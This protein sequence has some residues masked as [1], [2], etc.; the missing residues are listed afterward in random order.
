MLPHNGWSMANLRG[1][2]LR[3]QQLKN[4]HKNIHTSINNIV[5]SCAG[6][7][8]LG[9]HYG[10]HC[11]FFSSRLK[12]SLAAII[13]GFKSIT[14]RKKT[15]WNF[16]IIYATFFYC[17]GKNLESRIP[18]LRPLSCIKF[19]ASVEHCEVYRFEFFL[20]RCKFFIKVVCNLSCERGAT[21]WNLF[22][23][24]LYRFDAL[25]NIFCFKNKCSCSFW[26]PSYIVVCW[27]QPCIQFCNS[28]VSLKCEILQLELVEV[29]FENINLDYIKFVVYNMDWCFKYILSLHKSS[30]KNGCDL[31]VHRKDID[32]A[33]KWIIWGIE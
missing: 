6:T 22:N 3:G 16:K 30:D 11:I 18:P 13:F 24:C 8:S 7:A 33:V 28:Y 25:V 4:T 21:I 26:V 31:T 19:I 9:L 23:A 2:H 15:F 10:F 12:K 17:F 20:V 29:C 5:L 27:K 1:I 32:R 14:E